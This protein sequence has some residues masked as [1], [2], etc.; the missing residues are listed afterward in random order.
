MRNNNL[1]ADEAGIAMIAVVMGFVVVSLLTFLVMSLSE[2]QVEDAY[3]TYREDRILASVE[4]ELERY[5]AHLT[6]NGFYFTSK[7]DEA[8]RA[9]KCTEGPNTGTVRQ[10]G[11]PWGDLACN[12]W[13]YQDPLGGWFESPL[14]TATTDGE[15]VE[16]QLEIA[17]PGAGTPLQ[18][19]VAGRNLTGSELRTIS[20]EMR[21]EA[22]SEYVRA[23]NG[24][25]HY[26]SNVDVYGKVYAAIDLGFRSPVGNV[27]ADVFAAGEIGDGTYEPPNYLDGAIA[28]LGDPQ[29]GQNP[30]LYNGIAGTSVDGFSFDDLWDQM[31]AVKSAACLGG[32]LCLDALGDDAGARSYMIEPLVNGAGGALRI[33]YSTTSFSTSCGNIHDDDGHLDSGWNLLGTFP[34]PTNGAVWANG[35][36][37]LGDRDLGGPIAEVEGSFTIYA[38]DDNTTLPGIPNSGPQ[39]VIIN[40]SIKI[41]ERNGPDPGGTATFAALASAEAYFK[42]EAGQASGNHLEYEGSLLVQGGTF[43]A[44]TCGAT[45]TDP[46]FTIRGSLTSQGTGAMSGN[47]S[48]RNYRFDD[49]L[50]YIR[51]PY[52][53]LINDLWQWQNWREIAPPTWAVS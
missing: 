14:L 38:G 31:L 32:G 19:L 7:V 44:S 17:P 29:P 49:R 11:Q 30:P 37:I 24:D 47:F 40:K 22:L 53:P 27:H 8:E 46:E 23:S 48:P 5:A 2:R 26:G 33:Y 18:I 20:A 1:H 4:A 41:D 13:D 28:Y 3:A 51:P 16:V 35:D 9:R 50:A 36:V 39:Y 34:V 43:R 6:E 52:F 15:R 45:S 10:P 21:A 12:T 25:L 42:K